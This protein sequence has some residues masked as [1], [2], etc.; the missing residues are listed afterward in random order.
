MV[1][2]V[3]H[4]SFSSLGKSTI[5]VSGNAIGARTI[6]TNLRGLSNGS[7][8]K[9]VY[10]DFNESVKKFYDIVARTNDCAVVSTRSS[11]RR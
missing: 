4:E 1:G 10:F 7:S 2:R 6:V 8:S 11:I 3:L 5:Y 9:V